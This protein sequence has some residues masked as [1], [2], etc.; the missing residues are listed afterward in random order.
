MGPPAR[1]AAYAI[2]P[3]WSICGW[4]QAYQALYPTVARVP[5]QDRNLL[6][7]VFTDPFVRR[8][9]PH[10]EITSSH[11]LAEAGTRLADT[12]RRLARLQDPSAAPAGVPRQC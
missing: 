11:F 12:A 9:L 2:A 7:L 4:N 10:W 3:D 8:L 5:V 6:W 1:H